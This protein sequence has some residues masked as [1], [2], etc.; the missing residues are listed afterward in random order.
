LPGI[1]VFH[2]TEPIST[3]DESSESP[4]SQIIFENRKI[5][6]PDD[7]LISYI[8]Q[9]TGKIKPLAIADLDCFIAS[10]LEMLSMGKP[11]FLDGIGSIQKKKDGQY[12]FS[13]EIQSTKIDQNKN[14]G[15]A[16]KLSVFEDGKY[17]PKTNPLQKILAVGLLLAGLVIVLLG[18]YY[19]YNRS[20][21]VNT[22]IEEKTLNDAPLPQQTVDSTAKKQDSSLTAKQP[23]ALRFVLESTNNKKRALHRYNQL[24]S[25]SIDVKMDTP[26]SSNFKLFFLIPCPAEDT[27]RIKDSLMNYYGRR[28]TIEK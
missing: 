7:S 26:D 5:K 27:A 3:D 16:K 17:E 28:V 6:E 8:K 4:S 20:N 21:N 23:V 2:F 10:G 18:G 12:E 22:P 24:K 1:G 13:R 11:F 15:H 9:Q 14:A 19:L 25:L